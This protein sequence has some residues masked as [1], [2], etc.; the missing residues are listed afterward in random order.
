[1]PVTPK[2]VNE[3]FFDEDSK[4]MWYVFGVSFSQYSSSLEQRTSSRS[5][6]QSTDKK[7]IEIVKSSLDSENTITP[8]RYKHIRT[9]E[10][11]FTYWL[12]LNNQK[13]YDDIRRRGLDVPKSERTFPESIE[14]QYLDHFV[15]G[16]FDAHVSCYNS[17]Y[18]S[19]SKY[20]PRELN[21]QW[22]EIHFNVPFLR[23]LYEVLVE[24]AHIKSGREFSKSPLLIMDKDT[25]GVYDFLY[26]DW[27]FIQEN[28]LY[29]P[30]KK[31]G[32]R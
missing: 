5:R 28:G 27:D 26:R 23:G 2:Y 32:L 31:Q 14:E 18:Q 12:V 7:L 10:D 9:G 16:F 15:R 4:A 1:M 8:K 21:R 30:S 13:I 3:H 25:R 20:N 24:H 22:L 6:W 29:L 11:F 19:T 17:T